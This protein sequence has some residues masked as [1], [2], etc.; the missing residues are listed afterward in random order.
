MARSP[1]VRRPA[2][3]R[4]RAAPGRARPWARRACRAPGLR[5]PRCRYS[6]AQAGWGV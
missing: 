1:L 4:R 2:R 3:G 5:R 6:Y